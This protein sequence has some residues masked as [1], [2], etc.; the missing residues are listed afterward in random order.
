M[1]VGAQATPLVESDGPP[2]MG[3]TAPRET[4]STLSRGFGSSLNTPAE[5]L[6]TKGPRSSRF[7]E[8]KANASSARFLA[9]SI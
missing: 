4:T 7:I 3:R 2:R 9:R 5:K 1:S 8:E 6:H